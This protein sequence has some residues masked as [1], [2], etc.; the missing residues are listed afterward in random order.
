[1]NGDPKSKRVELVCLP[2]LWLL[3]CSVSCGK[4]DAPRSISLEQLMNEMDRIVPR[5]NVSEVFY[6]KLGD[7]L[8][9]F[10]SGASGRITDDLTPT[11]WTWQ[12]GDAVIVCEKIGPIEIQVYRAGEKLMDRRLRDVV[13][14]GAAVYHA[15]RVYLMDILD[16]QNVRIIEV[17]DRNNRTEPFEAPDRTRV[18]DRSIAFGHEDGGHLVFYLPSAYEVM[19]FDTDLE[20]LNRVILELPEE[21]TVG[22]VDALHHYS[23]AEDEQTREAI[24]PELIGKVL[25]VMPVTFYSD[26]KHRWVVGYHTIEI[27][28]TRA[29]PG[30]GDEG[31][32][33][34]RSG[35]VLFAVDGADHA[36]IERVFLEGSFVTG[37]MDEPSS[38]LALETVEGP[39][40]GER[41]W[42]NVRVT[43]PW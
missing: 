28:G 30:L 18:S 25:G 19:V 23:E 27:T 29:G 24:A 34:T 26:P 36:P 10:D 32:F 6:G 4:G 33:L 1:M 15:G 41:A 14:V 11:T 2:L 12:S 40:E 21:Q 43:S 3:A 7:T 35:T 9:Y 39:E 16:E 5:S 37:L 17:G 22:E 31:P 13:M 42:R 20:V 38:L 8:Y